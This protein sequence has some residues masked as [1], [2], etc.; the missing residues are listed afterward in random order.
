MRIEI[1]EID[2][3]SKS[4]KGK[5]QEIVLT[6]TDTKD[7]S[8]RTKTLVSFGDG[9]PV[10]DALES[11]EFGPG[12]SAEIEL[13]KAGKYWNWVGISSEG[14]HNPVV[15]K[16]SEPVSKGT[17]SKSGWTPDPNRETAEERYFRNLAI[18]R[19]NALTNAVQYMSA[20]CGL[21]DTEIL[22]LAEKFFQYTAQDFSFGG[23]GPKVTKA[24]KEDFK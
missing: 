2:G 6:Y 19:Q 16:R 9:K 15:S 23:V 4:D 11:G 7:D 10:F 24:V 21:S 22:D 12:D 3:P 17:P 18:C 5:W 14:G 20:T 13:K 1:Q 8:T